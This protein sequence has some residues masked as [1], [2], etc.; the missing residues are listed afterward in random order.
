MTS[1]TS[2]RKARVTIRDVAAICGVSVATVSNALQGRGRVSPEVRERVNEAAERLGY[3]ASRT[4][5]GLRLGRHGAIGLV[6]P[7]GSAEGGE[8]LDVD[9]YLHI[10]AAAATAAIGD[11]M[12]LSLLPGNLRFAESIEVGVDGVVML[13]PIRND[14]RLGLALDRDIPVVTVDR[15]LGRPDHGL[16]V[17]A[18]NQPNAKLLLD[19]LAKGDARRICLLTGSATW[20]WVAD[21]DDAYRDWCESAGMEPVVLAL[22]LERREASAAS[23]VGEVLDSPNPPDA[24]LATSEQFAIGALQAVRNRRLRVPE[25]VQIVTA[26]DGPGART[27]DPGVTAIDLLPAEQARAAIELLVAAINGDDPDGRVIV[28]SE[29][30]VRGST[31][32]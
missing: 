27:A 3:R 11:H 25:D 16:W 1:G 29:L 21:N 32:A 19:L 28:R 20:S 7:R 24:F 22:D 8:Y 14:P 6:L 26:V 13:D 12:A 31:R 9:Y 10:A 18:D 15:D 4:A 2:P 5:R 23:A 30:R 17:A